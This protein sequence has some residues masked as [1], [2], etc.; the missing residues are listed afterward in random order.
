M[1]GSWIP[2][3]D[4]STTQMRVRKESAPPRNMVDGVLEIL[5]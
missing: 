4:P 2:L 5:S 1:A 3:L